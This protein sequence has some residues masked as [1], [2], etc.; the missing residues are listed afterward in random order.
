MDVRI[1]ALINTTLSD[2]HTIYVRQLFNREPL[3]CIRCRV[4]T[5]IS[6]VYMGIFAGL[7]LQQGRGSQYHSADSPGRMANVSRPSSL[8]IVPR[9]SASSI[10]PERRHLFFPFLREGIVV[11]V[12]W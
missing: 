11:V 4:A 3:S 8:R 5:E 9:C 12:R 7:P 2:L 1:S 10:F 6:N